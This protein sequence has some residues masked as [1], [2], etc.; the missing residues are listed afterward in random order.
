M[1][2]GESE[3]RS[4]SFCFLTTT[5]IITEISITISVADGDSEEKEMVF[6]FSSSA[7]RGGGITNHRPPPSRTNAEER[8]LSD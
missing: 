8:M 1:T 3:G 2:G 6:F 4:I 7:G 5:A